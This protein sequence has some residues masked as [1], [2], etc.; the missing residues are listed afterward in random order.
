MGV[1]ALAAA[2]AAVAA[3]A[4]TRHTTASTRALARTLAH[5][6]VSRMSL[7]PGAL[8]V[9]SSAEDPSTGSWLKGP[10]SRPGTPLL[11]QQHRFWRVPGDPQSVIAWIEAHPPAGLVAD[12]TGTGGRYGVTQEWA[13]MFAARAVTGR[14]SQAGVGVSATAATGGG[15][16]LRVDAY[17]VWMIT[18]PASEVIPAGVRSVLVSVDHYGGGPFKQALVTAPGKVARLVAFVDSRQLAQPGWH[19]C[20]AI[21]SFSRVLDLQFLGPA[22][23]SA[24]ALARAVEDA[25]GDLTFSIRGRR[26]RGLQEQ[27]S[28]GALLRTLRVRPVRIR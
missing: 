4:G 8:Q 17:A 18:R 25:C 7:P 1:V 10:T 14:I 20:P 21:G 19:S 27:A 15:T 24:V 9:S 3:A 22:G 12:G 6:L 5:T 23:T 13:V 16:A 28:L 26:Q 11:A 2:T